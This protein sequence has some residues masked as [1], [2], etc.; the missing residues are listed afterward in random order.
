M[1]RASWSPVKIAASMLGAERAENSQG[2]PPRRQLLAGLLVLMRPGLL[3]L[4]LI[5]LQSL[6]KKLSARSRTQI[7][8]PRRGNTPSPSKVSEP[9]ARA[10]ETLKL[11]TSKQ[12]QKE[13]QQTQ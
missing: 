10:Y 3:D 12:W 2:A 5:E 8:N 9:S 4:R 7:E 6:P 1:I 13:D 11:G